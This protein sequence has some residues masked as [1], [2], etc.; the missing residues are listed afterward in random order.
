MTGELRLCAAVLALMTFGG[1]TA[2]EN[3]LDVGL[4]ILGHGE[5]RDG[6][7]IEPKGSGFM[8]TEPEEGVDHAAFVMG[9]TRLTIN[10]KRPGLE[11]K[12][13]GQN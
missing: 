9:R 8:G 6:G 2:Q 13:A 1:L 11:A 10:Y 5:V 7:L 12:V 4:Q 3:S